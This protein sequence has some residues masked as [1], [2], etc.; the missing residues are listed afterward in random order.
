MA[1]GYTRHSL[2]VDWE[3][4]TNLVADRLG[5]D[6]ADTYL[7]PIGE[8]GK[9]KYTDISFSGGYG[10]NYVFAPRWL[11]ASSLSIALGY[12]K[13]ISDVARF[14]FATS[15]FVISISTEWGVLV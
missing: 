13:T 5:Q 2:S 4:M 14:R 15:L 10:Y 11:F 12:K 3:K 7:G 6:V 8:S 1:I 9:V